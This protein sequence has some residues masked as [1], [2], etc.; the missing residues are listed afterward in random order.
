MSIEQ[1]L[2]DYNIPIDNGGKN[3][4]P[5][6]VN[7]RCQ[8]PGCTDTSNH[9]GFNIAG[10]YYNC[11]K[12]GH[13]SLNDVISTLLGIKW[14]E[15]RELLKS[16]K[17]DFNEHI[18]TKKQALAKKCKL[19][20]NCSAIITSGLLRRSSVPLLKLKPSIPTDLFPDDSTISIA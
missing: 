7:I 4:Q 19:P 14:H 16:Y 1:L 20:I 3:W 9:G 13:H 2:K 17:S 6:W 15:A 12:C 10:N 5:G 11:W 8:M 18:N